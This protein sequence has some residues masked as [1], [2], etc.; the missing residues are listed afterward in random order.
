LFNQAVSEK[1]T[2]LNATKVFQV[3]DFTFEPGTSPG[4][5]NDIDSNLVEF[6]FGF[7]LR[8]WHKIALLFEFSDS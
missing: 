7:D 3:D 2:E 4:D 8:E 1:E 5:A 6:F